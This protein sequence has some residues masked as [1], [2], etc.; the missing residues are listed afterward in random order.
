MG[1]PNRCADPTAIS[2]P[3]D[4]GGANFVKAIKSVAQITM[5]FP[6]CARLVKSAYVS[7]GE[8]TD[9]YVLGY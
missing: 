2:A 4:E 3:Q 1:T 7:P 6:S 8:D 9:P 5:A